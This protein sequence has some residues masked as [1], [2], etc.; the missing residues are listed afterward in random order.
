MFGKRKLSSTAEFKRISALPRRAP[1][2]WD[3]IALELTEVLKRSG[4]EE[5]LWSIQAKALIELGEQGG[6]FGPICV[7]GGKT[8]ISLFAPYILDS[9]RPL[10]LLPASLIEKTQNTQRAKSVHWKIS[11]N[12]RMLSYDELGRVGAAEL[13]HGMGPDL[14][15]C[16]EAHRLKNKRAAV[17]KRVVRYMKHAPETKFVAMSG[18]FLVKS[19]KDF[20]HMNRWSLKEGACVPES[21][22]EVDEWADA[23]DEVVN[24]FKRVHPGPMVGWG[25]ELGTDLERA[26]AGFQDRMTSTPGV[27]ASGEGNVGASLFLNTILYTPSTKTEEHFEVLRTKMKRT[28]GWTF[29]EPALIWLYARQLALGFCGVWDPWPP[30]EWLEARGGW[31][32]FAREILTH[33]RTYDS[34][35][36]LA[37]AIDDGKVRDEDGTLATWRKVKPSFKV[38]PKDIWHDTTALEVC[39][40]WMKKAPG[41]VWVEHVFFGQELARRTGAPYFGADALDSKGVYL[42]TFADAHVKNPVPIICSAKACVEG[43]DLQ[44]TWDRNLITAPSPSSKQWEQLLGRT[45]RKHHRS[46]EV[47]VDVMIGCL[48]HWEGLCKA[49]ERAAAVGITMGNRQRLTLADK[50]LPREVDVLAQPGTMWTRKVLTPA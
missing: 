49:I 21:E 15:I 35:L 12:I 48:E 32:S 33:S 30:E 38:Q 24:P 8:L 13:L 19:I 17:T 23:L 22:V 10:L 25:P 47:N 5:T 2:D 18:T 41:I 43:L 34:E 44:Y 11:Q 1:R 20:A 39:E 31:A 28:D 45:H 7:G 26:R 9:V 16:D 27:V 46:D 42:Q 50:I 37:N 14:I 36:Q 29:S 3:K 4:G 6:M 40:R